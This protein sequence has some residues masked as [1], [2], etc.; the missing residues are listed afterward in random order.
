MNEEDV[1]SRERA[2]YLGKK[3]RAYLVHVYT[4]SGVAFAFLAAREIILTGTDPQWV[5]IWLLIAGLIDATDGPLARRWEVKWRAPRIGGDLID[6]IVDFLTFAFLPLLLVWR[7]EWL[8]TLAGIPAGLWVVLAMVASLLAFANTE[9]KQTEDGFFR[10]FPSYWN[11]VAFYVGLWATNYAGG[12]VFS[13]VV[14]L[15]LAVLTLLPVRFIYPNRAPPPWR[16]VVTWG[17]A[18]WTVL[19]LVMLYYYPQLPGW[20]G[21]W[22]LMGLSLAYPAFY[23]ALSFYL[24]AQSDDPAASETAASA[25]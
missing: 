6:N 14:L 3:A 22:W 20:G 17:A 1:P 11:I 18:G 2:A 19:L 25:P 7:M 8:P 5:F 13:L 15:V 4:A 12:K 9:A 24:D 10:G 21:M 23:F 16:A